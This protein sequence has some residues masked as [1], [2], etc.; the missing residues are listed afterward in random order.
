[1]SGQ[2]RRGVFFRR[3]G[4]ATDGDLIIVNFENVA[5]ATQDGDFVTLWFTGMAA[6][7]DDIKVY[8]SMAQIANLFSIPP[9]AS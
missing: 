2:S 5:Y 7:A 3:R 9:P 4:G 1:M 8:A 6:N